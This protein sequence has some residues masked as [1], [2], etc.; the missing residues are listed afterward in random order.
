MGLSFKDSLEQATVN[1]QVENEINYDNEISLASMPNDGIA[2]ASFEDD[3]P[4][5]LAYS[6][7]SDKFIV[8]NKYLYYEEYSDDVLS[9]VDEHKNIILDDSQINLT[10]ET[11]SQYIPFEINRYYD[12]FDLMTTNLLIQF[13]NKNG[14][15]D[16][17]SPINVSYNSAK[18]RFAWLV[19]SRV[20]AVE[21]K[22]EFEIQA[23]G[24]NSRG[25][26][27]IWK[28]RPNGELNILKSL[29]TDGIVIP[30]K[31]W[32]TSFLSQVTEQVALAQEAAR[33]AQEAA[34]S[35]E[36]RIDEQVTNLL[37]EYYTKDEVDNIVANIDI[38]EQLDEVKKEI[39]NI[40]GLANFN[41][42]YDGTVMTF[43]NGDDVIKEI[44]INSD[45]S[46][47][48][49]T[50]YTS[51]IQ[52][53]IDEA[54]NE[55][56]GNLNT[57]SSTT[58]ERLEA[59]D[60]DLESIHS[61][62]DGLPETLASDYYTKTATDETF[63][64]KAELTNTNNSVSA[65]N[66]SIE[67][68]KTN[69]S[70]LSGKV[71][72]IE[73]TVNGIDKSPRLTYEAT[74][75]EEY[76]YTLWEI[77]GEG[78]EGEK[79]N[80]KNQFKIQGG[81]GSGSSSVLKIEYIT[82][83]PLVITAND[84]AIIKYNFSGTDSSGDSVS[85][86]VATWKVAGRVV[87]TNTAVSGENEFD[88][89]NY[90]TIGT[91][92]VQLSI[93]DDAG[94]L[95]TKTWTVQKIDV[96]LD[97][98]FNDKLTY[99]IGTVSF[100][101][102]P[103]GAISKDVHFVLDGKEIGVVTTAA[104]GIPMGYTLPTQTHGSHLLDVYMT[105]TVNGNPIESNHISKDIIW[106]DAT[107]TIPVIGCVQQEFT[108]KQYATT[109]ISYT[110]YDPSTETPTVV[111]AVDGTPTST[112]TLDGNTQIWQFKST[113]VGTHTLTITCGETVKTLTVT[114]EK[115]DIKLEPVTSGLV[116]DFDPSGKSNNDADR[117]WHNDTVAMT[118]S[119]N[120]DWINGGYQLDS[121]GDQYFCIKAGT[122]ATIDYQLFADDAKKNGK[123]FKVVFKT[124]NIKN[125]ATSFI[126]CMNNNIG[127]DMKVESA[128]IYS[129]NG[130]LY[131]PYCEEDIIEFEFNI[132]KNT[133]IPM[134]L[135]YEDGVPNRPMIY[136]SDSSFWQTEPQPITIGSKDCDVHIY[137]M[138][139]Y[140]NS[141]T[142]RGI[143]NNFIADARNA[144]EMV[145]RY[146]RNQ[147][148]DE[149]SLLSPEVLAEKCPDL[150]VI[151]VDAPW[152][153]ND[154]D[155]KVDDTTVRMIYKNGDPVLDNWT[156]TGARHSGQGTSSNEYGYAGRNIDLIMDTDTSVFT[157]GDGKT[158]S[159]TITL[160]RDSV[161]TDYLNVKVNIASSENENNAQFARRYNQYNPFVRSAK[162]ND[163]KV[164]DTMEFYN[165]VVFVR[166]RDENVSNHREFLDTNTHFY[167]IGNVGDSKKTDDTRV[168]NNKDPKECVIE[169]TDFN[170]PLAEFPTGNPDGICSVNNW[171]EGNTAYDYLYA[172][173]KYKD[174]KFKSFGSES[175]EFRYE[176]KGI[177]EEQR[178]E[179]INAWRDFYKFVVTSTDE[180]FYS[181]LK[182]Y[183]V[184]DS[185][186]YYYLFTE[187]YLMVDNRAKNSFWHYGKVY[188]TEEEA[189]ALGE[190]AGAY[191]INNEQ[192]SIRSGYRWD[193]TFGYDFDTSIGIDNT[194]KLVLTYGQ[195]DTDY[196]VTSE[197]ATSYIYRA[198]ESTFFCRTRD[199]F[200]SEMQEMFVN[201]ENANAWSANGLITQ[202]D[203]AQS[204]FPEE[205]WRLDIQRKY[206]RTYQGVSIDNSIAGT[207]NPRFLVEMLNGRKKYQRRM[208]E[209]NQELYM[210]TKYFGKT[211]TQDQIM[212]RFNNPET[213]VVKPDFTLYLTP[214]SDMYIGVKFG[215]V[216]PVNF[217]AKAG[218]QYEV[219]Y[220]IDAESADITLIYGASFIQAIGDLSKC[221]VG[222]NDFSKA[223]RLQSLTIGSDIEG[224]T[225][226]YMTKISLGNNKLLEYLD[227]RNVTGLSSV[228]DLSECGNLL[229]LHAKGSGATGVIFA[230]GG[231]LEKAYI[232]SVVSL[233][234]KNLNY[235]KE[236][237]VESYNNLQTIV[238]ENTPFVNTYEIVNLSSKLQTLRLIGI[239]WDIENDNVLNRALSL[240]GI[241]NDGS[242][243]SQS[244]LTGKVHVPVIRQQP[245]A[246]YTKAWN[247]L[248][249]VADTII[250]QFAV[251]FMNA[252]G[253]VLEVQYVDK[254][255]DAIDPTTRLENPITPTI[256]S[257]I[258]HDFTFAGWDSSLEDVFAPRI[259]TATYTESLRRY[260]IKY[261]SKGSVMQES[262]GLY[263]ENVPYTGITPTY[264]GEES[265]YIYYL[266]NRWDKSGFIDGDKVVNAVFDRFEYTS[267]SFDNKELNDLTPVEIY[268]L[269]TLNIADKVIEDKDGYSITIGN[270]ID[271]DD[272]ESELIISEKIHFNGKNYIDT[273]IKLFD[274][275]KDFVLAIDYEFLDGNKLNNVLAQCYQV[276]GSN[277][278]KL[279]YSS[280][281][282]FTWGTVAQSVTSAN[283]REMI[284]IRHKK[285][286]NNIMIYNSNLDGLEVTSIELE[287][288]KNTIG[289]G[290]LVFGCAKADDGFYENHAIGNVNW[291]KVWYK[292]LG[293]QVCRDLAIWT[294]EEVKFEACG[295]RRYYL[296]ENTSKRCSFS[297]LASHLLDRTAQWNN[298][299][300]SIGGWKDSS[301][302]NLLNTRL[303][304]A[305]PSQIRALLKQCRIPSSIGNKSTEIDVANCYIAI[306]SAIELDPT[307]TSEPYINEGFPTISYMTTNEAR[308]RMYNGGVEPIQY[309]TRSPNVDYEYYIYSINTSGV[310]YGY[311]TPTT[312]YGVLIEISF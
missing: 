16:F 300:T 231:K 225:N 29:S 150:R 209:R 171:K 23:R 174:G 169:I 138:K 83:S 168:N 240:R 132:N 130:S 128:N 280:D 247:D 53:K 245:L 259:I 81:S 126:S 197:G 252:D 37:S 60:T 152:F 155:N 243:I 131:S 89:T 123:E 84:S 254:G 201:R 118:V 79:R 163:P 242:E 276:N 43:Y 14:D 256:E 68:N 221:Y 249:V 224:Y 8:S 203:N 15:G 25:D 238:I 136:T 217:R 82:T 304:K 264:T 26:E 230:N 18:I 239:Y 193:L 110:V 73:T 80:A 272:I 273:G 185:A 175:Y 211:A 6:G 134:V 223:S 251:T 284:I 182:E 56:Q 269:T 219:P 108:A 46:V 86:G 166:E 121:N 204:Q 59:I 114:I 24:A 310:L 299:N 291:C 33:E 117:L 51:S 101:Y 21:G 176:M 13:R 109:N 295:F 296:T 148:Y 9:T 122:S 246:D 162:F 76:T 120:F 261:I 7:D 287:R 95:V 116:F 35:V 178:E 172:P 30:D 31:S 277:G 40:D 180:E 140:N 151:I 77:E 119:D 146:N 200:K 62:I 248:E 98:T 309:W 65:L 292:D 3:Y 167:A 215:N 187:R 228:V 103:Y 164:K 48:W 293:D 94:S 218:I 144:E 74:Y 207:A 20:T 133:D 87:A 206:M 274:E 279:S 289:D 288:T 157:L 220:S 153:T 267:T 67:S 303:Y 32:I 106:Y 156:C 234:M 78:T 232:P 45:P 227:I 64:T 160:T 173:Y 290:T 306:P 112:I 75:D 91:Q 270:D 47:E 305:F 28:T 262:T 282:K 258:S 161:P 17:V 278:F 90:I 125:R 113:E 198:A 188:I 27:Y 99:P 39:A 127:L 253:N 226:S 147:I 237:T 42:E 192:A 145:A 179:N 11:N 307:K 212:M 141:L 61:D 301:L 10:Q 186:L 268:A 250:E 5:M 4:V 271:Y 308:M 255:S 38:S 183:F 55:V 184:V 294:H 297:L 208:F 154:K 124:T 311:N 177:T 139:A 34:D 283:K 312:K 2:V 205:L 266:F 107:S 298:T 244:V 233:T 71:V 302:N 12:G 52:A 36:V 202:W 142:D 135:T 210:A 22:V 102:T 213:Y 194:G 191:I 260:T 214:Y 195:E 115:L 149:N 159:K 158:T 85:D 93:T 229:E 41:V 199:L 100:D 286:D 263:G 222:D 235:I 88:I 257:T 129:S 285:G 70:T 57:Y 190:K 236:F 1:A 137:R 189:V 69:I 275:D 111:L 97:S 54:K 241:S 196:Y 92:K 96:R 58:D 281:V 50:A 265:A 216:E 165:C 63:A 105:A 72:E 181:K 49:T 170:V 66:S 104:S 44:E 143:L 19:D